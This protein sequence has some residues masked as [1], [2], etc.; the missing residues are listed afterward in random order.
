LEGERGGEGEGEG[1]GRVRGRERCSD[2]EGDT[3]G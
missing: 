2:V 1:Q 3:M